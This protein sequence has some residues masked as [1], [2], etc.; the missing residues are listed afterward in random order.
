M[1]KRGAKVLPLFI[2]AGLVE[3]ER[4]PITTAMMQAADRPLLVVALGLG[5]DSIAMLVVIYE[6]GIRPDLILFADTGGEKPEPTPTSP[7]ST[8]GLR[9][10]ASR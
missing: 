9:A 6:L 5:R 8:H 1:A 7:C 2:H 10:S 3:A 4:P